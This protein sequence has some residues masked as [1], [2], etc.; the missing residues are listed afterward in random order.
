M[1]ARENKYVIVEVM[2]MPTPVILASFMN[3]SDVVKPGQKV[4]AAGMC[5][6][7]SDE[8]KISVTCYGQSQTLGIQSRSAADAVLIEF[9]LT[10][11]DY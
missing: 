11:R 7:S 9:F 2:G 6:I 8:G 3:H 5:K 1:N 4:I 10:S